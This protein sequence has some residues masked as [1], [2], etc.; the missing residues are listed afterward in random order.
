MVKAYLH[1]LRSGL[2]NQTPDRWFVCCQSRVV[3][4]TPIFPLTIVGGNKRGVNEFSPLLSAGGNKRGVN[5]WCQT[6]RLTHQFAHQCLWLAIILTCLIGWNSLAFGSTNNNP[7]AFPLKLSPPLMAIQSEGLASSSPDRTDNRQLVPF[8]AFL[9][10]L[11]I[12]GW[13]QRYAGRGTT[14]G[15]INFLTDV[16]LWGVVIGYGA[17][18][19]W[20]KDTYIAFAATHA[21]V[22][23]QGKDHQYYVDIGNYQNLDQFNEQQRRDRDFDQLYLSS[24]YWWEWDSTPNRLEFKRIRIQSDNALNNRYYVLGA[25]L[26]NHLISAIHASRQAYNVEHSKTQKFHSS[27]R[28]EIAPELGN[29]AF[30]LRLT[31]H[32]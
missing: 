5:Q 12:P 16:T 30:Q 25:V 3:G 23:T 18:G 4:M 31:G 14:V 26:L 28:L 13:G 9:Q 10:S 15:T 29:G 32:F 20:R 19:N 7:I 6:S 2:I 11:V 8:R 17:Y 24:G 21:E 27:S 22:N 1:L